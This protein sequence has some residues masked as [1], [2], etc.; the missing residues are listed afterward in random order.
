MN[1]QNYQPQV[2]KYIFLPRPQWDVQLEIASDSQSLGNQACCG[3]ICLTRSG[4]AVVRFTVETGST[5]RFP[6][7]SVFLQ[8]AVSFLQEFL[9]WSWIGMCHIK[10]VR[11][12]SERYLSSLDFARPCKDRFLIENWKNTGNYLTSSQRAPYLLCLDK[13]KMSSTSGHFAEG[14]STYC[15]IFWFSSRLT[16]FH[17]KVF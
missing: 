13:Y 11:M 4:V 10:D 14:Y 5:L 7:L 9:E 12:S 16:S 1:S 2:E 3:N 15:W 8:V 6:V 17:T